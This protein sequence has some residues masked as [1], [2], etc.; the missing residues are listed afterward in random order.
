MAKDRTVEQ[1]PVIR[2]KTYISDKSAILFQFTTARPSLG[3]LSAEII[4]LKIH[5]ITF[6]APF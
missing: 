4:F 3:P 1:K 5:L 2:L 6:Q